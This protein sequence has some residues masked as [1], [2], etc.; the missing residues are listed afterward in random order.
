MSLARKIMDSSENDVVG[1]LLAYDLQAGQYNEAARLD[2]DRWSRW[3][4]QI[5]ARL[6]PLLARENGVGRRTLLEVG[7]GEATTMGGVLK[8]LRDLSPLSFGLDI[9]WSRIH[10]G[11]KWLSELGQEA[12]LF[13]ADL[14][15]I[16]FADNS[17]DVVYSVHSLEPNG[18]REREAIAECMRVARRYVV[19]VEPLYELA[20]QDQR[21][22][23][24]SHG[25][26]RGLRSAAEDLGLEISAFELLP[27]SPNPSN[28][29][30][31]MVLEKQ[32]SAHSRSNAKSRW[33][34]PLTHAPMYAD[35]DI[36]RVP[37]CGLVYPGI[38]GIPL[39]RKERVV[40]ASQLDAA[41]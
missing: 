24:L 20:N 9:S 6:R 36:F 23:M 27:F 38:R 28:P 17:I 30:G 11:Q 16:P 32:A 35:R 29:S 2:R 39:L 14:F 33:R 15:D 18:T 26:V 37:D 8:E 13:V 10:E 25:Y 12:T 21:E 5:A 31:V 19:L 7:C 1:T 3:C 40:V 22:R 34:D 4:R 41:E